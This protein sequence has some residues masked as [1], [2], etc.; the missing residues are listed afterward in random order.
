[1]KNKFDTILI[2]KI[3][4]VVAI[5][6]LLGLTPIGYINIG[7]LQIT[8]VHIVVIIVALVLG[9][10]E[11]LIAGLTFGITSI[12]AG[13]M[14]P[15]IFT[16]IFLN[17]LVSIVPRILLPLIAYFLFAL[18]YRML[19]HRMANRMAL[20][21]AAV[22]SSII[23][24]LLHTVLVIAGI[25]LFRWMSGGLTDEMLLPIIVTL[26]SVNMPLEI[27]FASVASGLIVPTLYPWL[28]KEKINNDNV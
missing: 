22:F 7:A 13:L 15:G 2:T 18:V 17:P 25:W 10:R 12:I 27:L 23:A 24:T 5:I 20:M 4:T 19:R 1:M 28:H 8:T 16:P 9:M 26:L 6:L 11:G 14:T 21:I 3:A